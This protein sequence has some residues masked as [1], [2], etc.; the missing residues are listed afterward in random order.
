MPQLAHGC[1]INTII[2]PKYYL[3]QGVI[4]Y[5]SETWGGQVSDKFITEHCSILDKLIRGDV[6]LADRGFDISDS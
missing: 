5:V 6:V 3:P 4:S 2:Q 1:Y